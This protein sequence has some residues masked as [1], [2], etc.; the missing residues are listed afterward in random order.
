VRLDYSI[1]P[2][3][4]CL[5]SLVGWDHHW[6]IFWVVYLLARGVRLH[7]G[8][9]NMQHPEGRAAETTHQRVAHL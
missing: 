9:P 6:V 8:H 2:G 4:A 3:L 1:W 7:H 5:G